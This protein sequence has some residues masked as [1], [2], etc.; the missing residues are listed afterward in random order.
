MHGYGGASQ[1]LVIAIYPYGLW[2]TMVMLLLYSAHQ[3]IGL[4]VWQL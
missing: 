3:A 1:Q 2:S 4:A